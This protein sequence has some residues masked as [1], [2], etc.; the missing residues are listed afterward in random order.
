[1]QISQAFI[2]NPILFLPHLKR[3]EKLIRKVGGCHQHTF[4]PR[5]ID[6]ARTADLFSCAS[7]ANSASVLSINEDTP[8]N[9]LYY[10]RPTCS[11]FTQD[12]NKE[13]IPRLFR[14]AK[15]AVQ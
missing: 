15:T 1:M 12:C 3:K 10:V 2:H 14:E 5:G 4:T 13:F 7:R 8:C 9:V 11:S 6:I